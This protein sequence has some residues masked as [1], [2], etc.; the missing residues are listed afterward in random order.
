MIPFC[1]CCCTKCAFIDFQLYY[2]FY[3]F[4]LQKNLS[5]LLMLWLFPLSQFVKSQY[6]MFKGYH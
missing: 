6:D 5:L 3:Y 2:E 1:F 4:Y